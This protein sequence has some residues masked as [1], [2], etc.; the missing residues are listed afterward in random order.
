MQEFFYNFTHQFYKCALAPFPY[1]TEPLGM[2]DTDCW[3][4]VWFVFFSFWLTYIY[5]MFRKEILL[6][7]LFSRAWVCGFLLSLHEDKE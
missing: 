7:F 2:N 4:V 1:A 6:Q 5:F 3:F